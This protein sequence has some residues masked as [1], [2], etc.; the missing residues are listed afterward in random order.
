[1]TFWSM[2]SEINIDLEVSNIDFFATKANNLVQLLQT[3][4]LICINKSDLNIDL[5]FQIKQHEHWL[6]PRNR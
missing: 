5:C 3:S 1:M 6:D 2:V 4:N